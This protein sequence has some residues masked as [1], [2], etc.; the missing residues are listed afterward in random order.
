MDITSIVGIFFGIACVLLGNAIEGG[1]LESILQLTAAIIVFGGTLGAVILSFPLSHI[2]YTFGSMKDL[3]FGNIK[4]FN[5]VIADIV[6]LSY[7][8]R[9][10]GII[11]LEEDAH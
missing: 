5:K 8:A 4:D 7:K 2:L 10:D 11:A 1:H 6:A 9:K 3:F